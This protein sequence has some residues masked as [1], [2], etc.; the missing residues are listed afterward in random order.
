MVAEAG[1]RGAA[2]GGVFLP[3]LAL[4]PEP[5][6]RGGAVLP[7]FCKGEGGRPIPFPFGF[8][9]SGSAGPGIIAGPTR[10]QFREFVEDF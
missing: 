10:G 7:P 5:D 8:G 9:G 4:L 6:R 2:A 3:R 1:G